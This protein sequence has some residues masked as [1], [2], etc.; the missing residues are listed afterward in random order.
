[1]STK[2]DYDFEIKDN[3]VRKYAY[4]FDLDVMHGFM[5][6]SFEALFVKGSM[7]ELGS[8]KGD[9]TGR[10]L[11]FSWTSP[12]SR[13]RRRLWPMRAAS[14]ASG[15]NSSIRPLRRLPAATL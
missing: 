2:R 6:R 4:S 1:M 14:W 12:A 8:F 11:P 13:L 3:Q 7:L 15:S 10:L 5:I 9:F